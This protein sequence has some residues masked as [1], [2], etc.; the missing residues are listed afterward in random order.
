MRFAIPT[1]D[2]EETISFLYPKFS[3]EAPQTISLLAC[4]AMV[5]FVDRYAWGIYVESMSKREVYGEKRSLSHS[6]TFPRTPTQILESLNFGRSGEALGRSLGVRRNLT[7]SINDRN[8]QL[9]FFLQQPNHRPTDEGIWYRRPS[10]FGTHTYSR[11]IRH[12]PNSRLPHLQHPTLSAKGGFQQAV[13]HLLPH[14]SYCSFIK[15]PPLTNPLHFKSPS[16]YLTRLTVCCLSCRR[17]N[18]NM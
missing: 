1:S 5:F 18:G 12:V 3:T 13:A 10:C 17:T 15:V 11:C 16:P 4:S 8:Q 6:R 7:L 9:F 2:R 14:S